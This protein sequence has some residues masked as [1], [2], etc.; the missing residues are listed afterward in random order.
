MIIVDAFK[1]QGNDEM[2][3]PSTENNCELF[4]VPHNLTYDR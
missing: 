3:G 1:C 2:K 4:I